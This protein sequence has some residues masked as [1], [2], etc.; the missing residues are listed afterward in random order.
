MSPVLRSS[1]WR[2]RRRLPMKRLCRRTIAHRSPV[3]CVP[4][5]MN[6]RLVDHFG[7]AGDGDVVEVEGTRNC[8]GLL[9]TSTLSLSVPPP[10]ISQTPVAAF[11]VK[12]PLR[13]PTTVTVPPVRAKF[14]RDACVKEPPRLSA[15]EESEIVA[16]FCQAVPV[17]ASVPPATTILPAPDRFPLIVNV[18]LLTL[19]ASAV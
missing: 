16:W 15:P 8:N 14:P 5:G 11:R 18:P 4:P 3:R 9:E 19:I 7:A 1:E 17:I 12:F 13:T 2:Q 10:A 6:L